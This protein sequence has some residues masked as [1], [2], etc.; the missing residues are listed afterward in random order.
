MGRLK[1]TLLS[2]DNFPKVISDC[3]R[4]ID[5]QVSA[6]RGMTGLAIKGGYKAVKKFRPD[7]IEKS[8]ESL[9]PDFV[10]RMEPFYDEFK[11]SGSTGTMRDFAKSN[12]SRIANG[13]LTITDERAKK[14]DLA[15]LR[16]VYNKLRP[17]AQSSV[18]EALPAVGDLVQ[19]YAG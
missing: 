19:K 2:A 14:T 17:Y 5:S 10:D 11:A 16:K 12:S 4:L 13:L 18:E 9:L 7:V 1:E 6:K 3:K 8:L 15:T